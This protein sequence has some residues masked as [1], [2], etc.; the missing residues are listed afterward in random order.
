MV[1]A[2]ALPRRWD[3]AIWR[4][5]FE[6]EVNVVILALASDTQPSCLNAREDYSD[7]FAK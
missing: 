1:V 3:G 6:R 7:K 4:L 2:I 5:F